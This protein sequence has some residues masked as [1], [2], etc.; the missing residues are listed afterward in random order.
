M[1]GFFPRECIF[2]LSPTIHAAVMHRAPTYVQDRVLGI[3][4]L[5]V[6]N[7]DENGC[8]DGAYNLVGKIADKSMHIYLYKQM[9][10]SNTNDDEKGSRKR[11]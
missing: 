3:G 5:A 4:N 6:S 1:N 10:S 8:F 2:P 7:T 9:T 11:G